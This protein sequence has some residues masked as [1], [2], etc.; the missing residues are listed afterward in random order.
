MAKH[1]D[2]LKPSSLGHRIRFVLFR[3]AYEETWER[4]LLEFL[5]CTGCRVGEVEKLNIED[6]N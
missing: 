1:A 6:L 2:Q 3:Y 4:V 5:Y